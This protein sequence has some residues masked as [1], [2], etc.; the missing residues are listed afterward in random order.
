ML[1]DVLLM[2]DESIRHLL[3]QIVSPD[4]ELRQTIDHVLHQ[5]KPV[6]VALHP[7]VKSCDAYVTLPENVLS[8]RGEFAQRT[9]RMR[10]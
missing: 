7:H 4:P 10:F 8:A 9:N 1:V 3:L 6:Q 5:M 2:F